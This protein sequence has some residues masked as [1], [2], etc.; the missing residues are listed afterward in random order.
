MDMEEHSR[1][2]DG[3]NKEELNIFVDEIGRNKNS[4]SSLLEIEAPVTLSDEIEKAQK[5]NRK[6]PKTRFNRTVVLGTPDTIMSRSSEYESYYS[7]ETISQIPDGYNNKIDLVVDDIKMSNISSSA[8]VGADPVTMDDEL[9]QAQTRKRKTP[10]TRWKKPPGMPKRPLS[11]YNYFFKH[12]R[13]RLIEEGILSGEIDE[14]ATNKTC[15]IGF[16]S[17]AK[18]IATKWKTLD[19]ETKKLYQTEAMEDKKRYQKEVAIWKA[20][21]PEKAEIEKVSRIEPEDIFL[22]NSA[23]SSMLQKK[24][25]PMAYLRP[26]PPLPMPAF[27]SS[28][29]MPISLLGSSASLKR[30]RASIDDFDVGGGWAGDTLSDLAPPPSTSFLRRSQSDSYV[31]PPTF[32]RRSQSDSFLLP[33]LSDNYRVRSC[34]EL[35]AESNSI[36][37]NGYRPSDTPLAALVESLDPESM[38]FISGLNGG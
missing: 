12:E 36:G 9:E 38:H 11:A 2:P 37:G 21:Q 22:R 25:A 26:P 7:V 35:A 1:I 13:E 23:P 4:S 30:G 19:E 3:C 10:K 16:T 33:I 29:S 8:L 24:S 34:E 15:G 20:K 27:H 32:S 17:L 14:N 6:T 28:T 18:Q 31:P 5:K